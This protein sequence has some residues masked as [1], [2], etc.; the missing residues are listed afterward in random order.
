MALRFKFEI[1]KQALPAI[2]MLITSGKRLYCLQILAAPIFYAYLAYR[3]IFSVISHRFIAIHSLCFWSKNLYHIFWPR[4][5]QTSD[6]DIVLEVFIR[7]AFPPVKPSKTGIYLERLKTARKYRNKIQKPARSKNGRRRCRH[8]FKFY[9]TIIL[10]Y[11][12]NVIDP[13]PTK[14]LR[15]S[16]AGNPTAKAETDA[17]PRAPPRFFLPGCTFLLH[18]PFCFAVWANAHFFAIMDNSKNIYEMNQKGLLWKIGNANTVLILCWLRPVSFCVLAYFRGG[19]L[20]WG[21]K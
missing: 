21:G 18:H 5:C 2:R 3:V 6:H 17:L 1:M 8:F 19:G 14:F 20:K 9:H 12:W 11:K 16:P 13:V 7:K 15:R 10:W 4:G